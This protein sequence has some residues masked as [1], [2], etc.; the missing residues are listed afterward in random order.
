LD[1]LRTFNPKKLL[2]NNKTKHAIMST[3]HEIIVNEIVK[4]LRGGSA[5]I[6]LKKALDGLPVDARGHKPDQLPYSIWQLVEHIRIAQWDMLQFSLGADHK[7]PKWP[8]EYWVKEAAPADDKAWN[9]SLKQIDDD[10]EQ[11]INLFKKEDIY[12]KIPHGSGQ[13]ILREA[14]Q[15]ADHTAYHTSEIIVIRRLQGNYK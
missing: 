9:D 14:L 13:S 1:K 8:D 5:H 2:I 3:E 7:S 10:L 11:F 4:L 15:I 12:Q 6:G